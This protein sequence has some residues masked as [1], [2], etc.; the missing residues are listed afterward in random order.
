MRSVLQAFMSL[1]CSRTWGFLLFIGCFSHLLFQSWLECDPDLFARMAIG[2]IVFKTGS[3]PSVDPF[4]WTSRLPLWIDHEWLSGVVFLH[5]HES[6]GDWGLYILKLLFV[7]ATVT[8]LRAT[9]RLQ[10]HFD[11]LG[12]AVLMLVIFGSSFLWFSTVRCQAFTYLFLAFTFYAIESHR[13]RKKKW[14]LVALVPIMVGWVNLHGGFTLGLIIVGLY[15]AS[16]T[17]EAKKASPFLLGILTM[18]C[19][20]TLLNPYGPELLVTVYE[21]LRRPR[22][23]IGEWQPVHPLSLQA[24]C[25]TGALAIIATSLIYDRRRFSLSELLILAF[26]FFCGYRHSR[27]IPVALFAFFSL[28]AWGIQRRLASVRRLFDVIEMNLVLSLH[29]FFLVL[30]ALPTT[31]S[32]FWHRERFTLD[33][34]SYP[35]AAISWALEK[36]PPGKM[37]TPFR[38][39]SYVLWAAYPHLLISMDGRYEAVYPEET[40]RRN[41]RLYSSATPET[42]QNASDWGA[43]YALFPSSLVSKPEDYQE[44]WSRAYSDKNWTIL[45]RSLQ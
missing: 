34:S 6:F 16:S 10:T 32:L 21:A 26:C 1:I 19:V 42:F 18:L 25:I 36:L 9:Y 23:L 22:D 5:V 8:L 31:V 15:T 20:A 39:G 35:V 2:Q 43:D 45:R 7:V 33:Y 3:V 24:L 28:H 27:L 40:F 11:G 17:V 12:L 4:A 44:W 37:L 38:E 14:P 41:T 30:V 29:S 13:L